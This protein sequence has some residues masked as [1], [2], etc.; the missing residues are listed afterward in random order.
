MVTLFDAM[1]ATAN[2]LKTQGSA[3]GA[4]EMNLTHIGVP[5]YARQVIGLQSD[6]FDPRSGQG[7]GVRS[8][9]HSARSQ[10]AEQ[11]V[12]YQSGQKGFFDAF[13]RQAS[14]VSQVLGLNDVNGNTGMSAALSKL[15]QS[16]A[17]WQT[18]AQSDVNRNQVI[19]QA[20]SFAA[21][22]SQTAA[23]VQ[24]TLASAQSQAATMVDQI[25]GLVSAVSQFNAELNR[26]NSLDP[27]AEAQLYSAIEQLSSL[28][29]ITVQKDSSGL[30]SIQLNG[31]TALLEGGQ[32]H[33]LQLGF[34]AP[35]SGSAFPQAQP[36]TK[37]TDDQGRDITS[38]VSSGQL[39]GIL[40]YVNRFVPTLLGDANQQGDLN[41]LA[42]GLADSVNNALGGSIPLFQYGAGNPTNVAQSLAV[43]SS[44][45]A[46]DLAA[47]QAVNQNAP[48]DLTKIATG[49]NPSDQINGQGYTDFLTSLSSRANSEL[50]TKQDGLALQAQLLNQAQAMRETAQGV[51]MEQEAVNLLQFQR[52]FEASARL[53]S[54][55]DSL[56]QTAINM[57]ATS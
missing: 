2:A 9:I 35:P 49:K 14:G 8:D 39:G 52:A 42:Q 43:A 3:L 10:F 15:F 37:I 5:G 56:T 40:D 18:G 19:Q 16:F 27:S 53:I 22:V 46:A 48:Q 1:R 24:Q 21:T 51:S 47:D 7:G 29:P 12:W 57:V 34:V 23:Y 4:T 31:Q 30:L 38:L 20:R 28:A 33:K 55:I 54:V 17:N 32:Q 41:K 45:S 25:N 13:N 11:A 36:A 44:L 50:T 26:G 6:G